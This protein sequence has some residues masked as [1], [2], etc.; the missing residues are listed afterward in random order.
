M[1][2]N[3]PPTFITDFSFLI[4]YFYFFLNWKFISF[5]KYLSNQKLQEIHIQLLLLPMSGQALY[6]LQQKEVQEVLFR[7]LILLCC[8]ES[9]AIWNT[10]M[11]TNTTC[12]GNKGGFLQLVQPHEG[13]LFMTMDMG[14]WKK[15]LISKSQ[16]LSQ[17][18]KRLEK[19]TCW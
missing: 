18:A 11:K 8:L 19:E 5:T 3:K 2:E 13:H 4:N 16:I 7:S 12:P 10:H 17:V 6:C 14:H 9:A 15:K 1:R